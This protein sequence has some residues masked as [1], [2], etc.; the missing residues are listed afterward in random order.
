MQLLDLPDNIVPKEF[1]FARSVQVWSVGYAYR[2]K[3]DLDK[4]E[5][6]FRE[7]LEL[8]YSLDNVYTIVST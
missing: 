7:A 3:G 8:G 5:H 2:I 4:A 6:C 1:K